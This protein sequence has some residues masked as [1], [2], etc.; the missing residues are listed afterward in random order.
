[1]K[2]HYALCVTICICVFKTT[3][4]HMLICME[5]LCKDRQHTHCLCGGTWWLE[6]SGKKDTDFWLQ[7]L[8]NLLISEPYEC[9]V[10]SKV[11][12][13]LTASLRWT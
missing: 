13:F 9:I 5:H 7:I 3:S 6:D 8:L 1:M 2:K 10:Y 12:L 11:F 4:T